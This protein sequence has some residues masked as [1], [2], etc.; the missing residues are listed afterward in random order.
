MSI[1]MRKQG[2]SQLG[3]LDK[4]FQREPV[5]SHRT[6]PAVSHKAVPTGLAVQ[7]EWMDEETTALVSRLTA[8]CF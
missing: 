8:A 3:N 6:E 1:L 5:I 4:M 7:N 2:D